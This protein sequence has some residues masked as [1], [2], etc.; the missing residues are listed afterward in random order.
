MCGIGVCT[1]RHEIPDTGSWE[2]GLRSAST[3]LHF[4]MKDRIRE[5]IVRHP[6]PRPSHR[7]RLDTSSVTSSSSPCPGPC[8]G[9][10][11]LS[12]GKPDLA[13]WRKMLENA[14]ESNTGPRTRNGPFSGSL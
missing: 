5:S 12:V 11:R 10:W 4:G 8:Q 3:V 6:T 9:V 14:A 2:T 13:L 7:S 1:R